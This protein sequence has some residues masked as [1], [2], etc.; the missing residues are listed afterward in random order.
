MKATPVFRLLVVSF[1]L[2]GTALFLHARRKMEA[3]PATTPISRF[4]AQVGE[5][6]GR[7]LDIDPE[8]LHLL[9]PGD[10]LS[11][12]YVSQS[13]PMVDFFLA[14]FPTQ[15]TGDTIHSPK[16]CIPAAGWTPIKSSIVRLPSP[17]GKTIPANL[18]VVQKGTDRELVLYWYQAHGRVIASEYWARFY[19]VADAIRMNRTD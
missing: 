9:G 4:P 14:F 5:W 15:E 8:I 12:S 17:S 18:Y 16:N 13:R 3:I 7:D 2:A 10:F 11:R 19:L 1:L 6:T